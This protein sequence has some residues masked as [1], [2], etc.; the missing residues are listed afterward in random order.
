MVRIGDLLKQNAKD[1]VSNGPLQ[2]LYR[3][4]RHAATN[5]TPADSDP[6]PAHACPA[7]LWA[8]CVFHERPMSGGRFLLISERTMNRHE[9]EQAVAK[10]IGED[11]EEIRR[12]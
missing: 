4:C 10:A 5:Q 3:H 11:T 9:V 8:G 1:F 7:M 2:Q 6:L 12:L